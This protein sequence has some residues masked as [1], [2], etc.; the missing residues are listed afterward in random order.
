MGLG[1]GPAGVLGGPGA[2]DAQRHVKKSIR[3]LIFPH[4]NKYTI[5]MLH[6]QN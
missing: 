3:L 5:D 4:M 6:M 1:S 2:P